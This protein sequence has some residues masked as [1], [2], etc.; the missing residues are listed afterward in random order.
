MGLDYP[1]EEYLEEIRNYKGD[2]PIEEFV[3]ILQYNWYFGPEWCIIRGNKAEFHTGG[4]SGNEDIIKAILSNIYLTNLYMKYEMW[5]RGG[6]YYFK[7][8]KENL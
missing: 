1:T 8:C 6:H 2:P 4:W 7:I 5:K 3:K